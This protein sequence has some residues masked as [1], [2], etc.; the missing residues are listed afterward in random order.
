MTAILVS[1]AEPGALKALGKSSS[2]PESKGADVIIPGRG[3]LVGV[4]RKVFPEDFLASLSDGRGPRWVMELSAAFEFPLLILEG[5]PKWTFSGQLLGSEYGPGRLFNRVQLRSYLWSL[6]HEFSI[7]HMWTDDLSDTCEVVRE[8]ARWAQKPHHDSIMQR[9][10]PKK[11]IRKRVPE[12]DWGIHFLQGVN[13]IGPEMAG[14]IYDHFGRVPME[15]SVSED[16][17]LEVEGIGPGRA[18]RLMGVL[19]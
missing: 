18:G 6:H 15:W 8:L 17:L 4:Q 16:E 13:G 5:R 14:R 10:G 19:K 9:P 12:R 3:F 11:N 2:L 7:T 1:P